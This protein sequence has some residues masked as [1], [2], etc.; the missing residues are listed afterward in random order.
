MV[1]SCRAETAS[2][3]PSGLNAI[4]VRPLAPLTFAVAVTFR[5]SM[6]HSLMS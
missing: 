4:E 6:L 5:L 3:V 2:R 1:V